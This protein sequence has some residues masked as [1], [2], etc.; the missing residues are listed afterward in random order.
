MEIEP[1]DDGT[2]YEPLNQSEASRSETYM[3]STV[4]D[5]SDEDYRRCSDVSRQSSS[6]YAEHKPLIRASNIN[7]ERNLLTTISG[8]LQ[9]QSVRVAPQHHRRTSILST[10]SGMR[11][12]DPSQPGQPSLSAILDNGQQ[13]VAMNSPEALQVTTVNGNQF[14]CLNLNQENGDNNTYATNSN[15]ITAACYASMSDNS[16]TYMAAANTELNGL[17]TATY[18]TSPLPS[19]STTSVTQPGII[20]APVHSQFVIQR[21]GTLPRQYA[22]PLSQQ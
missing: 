15:D 19:K 2:V 5:L 6:R 11:Y 21:V 10:I 12:V 18:V 1:A 20:Q 22:H 16:N 14:V 4:S 8:V 9:S 13:V 7:M 17:N 3:L